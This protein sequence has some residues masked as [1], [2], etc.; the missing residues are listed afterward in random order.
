VLRALGVQRPRLLLVHGRDQESRNALAGFLRQHGMDPIVMAVEAT[1]GRSL[2]EKFEELA[3]AVDAAIALATPDDVG[4]QR[5]TKTPSPRARQNVW[6][7][8][9]WFWGALGR[10]RVLV[11]G[12][13]GVERPSDLSGLLIEN[14]VDSPVERGEEILDWIESLGWPRPAVVARPAPISPDSLRS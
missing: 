9:G 3:Q 11:L 1:R 8:V 12:K 14:F 4:Y 10:S 2:P 6:V 13:E 7:E 5:D